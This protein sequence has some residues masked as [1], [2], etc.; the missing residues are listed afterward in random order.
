MLEELPNGSSMVVL[1]A[2]QSFCLSVCLAVLVAALTGCIPQ[3]E[4]FAGAHETA[5]DALKADDAQTLPR[6]TEGGEDTGQPDAEPLESISADSQ[7]PPLPDAAHTDVFELSDID[8]GTDVLGE[9]DL[10]VLLDSIDVE[11]SCEL[12]CTFQDGTDKECG[13]DGCGSICGYCGFEQ[14]C[15]EGL[16]EESC[17]PQ[18]EGKQC[19]TDGCYG[20]CPPGCTAGFV[21]VDG[22]C[23]PSCDPEKN[24]NGKEC[25]PDGCDGICG[26]CLQNEV[27]DEE[28]GN[29]EPHPCGAVDPETGKCTEDNVL[30]ECVDDMLVQTACKSLGENFFCK[31]DGPSQKYVCGK[32]C[33]PQCNWDDGTPKECGY[34]GCY[35]VCGTCPDGWDCEAGMCWPQEGAE[36]AWITDKGQCIDDKLWFCS[37]DELSVDDCGASGKECQFV[38]GTMAY[39]CK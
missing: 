22:Q 4:D 20:E 32:G 37:G 8:S 14:A 6:E 2:C 23:H 31:W 19:G 21:C 27:C 30:L 1:P 16:C 5:S 15:V 25:G 18:C 35:G 29:C 36:C 17:S 34:D 9:E 26:T 39:E 38:T 13:S 11:A 3:Y 28:T 7:Y 12:N 33:V 10:A 24:C